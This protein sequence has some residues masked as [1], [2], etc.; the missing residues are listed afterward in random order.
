MAYVLHRSIVDWFSSDMIYRRLP[1]YFFNDYKAAYMAYQ[2]YQGKKVK[3]CMSRTFYDC[4][5]TN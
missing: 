3:F 2:M 5:I 1:D 4:L